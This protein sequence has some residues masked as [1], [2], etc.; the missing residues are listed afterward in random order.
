MFP[1]IQSVRAIPPHSHCKALSALT[2]P[3]LDDL[4]YTECVL[5]SLG[6]AGDVKDSVSLPLTSLLRQHSQPRL[7]HHSKPGCI[8]ASL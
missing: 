2:M 8:A 5:C 4:G 6:D 7:M 1:G 3:T